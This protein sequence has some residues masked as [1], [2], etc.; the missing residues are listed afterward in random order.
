M[1]GAD[2]A[3]PG[4]F[5]MPTFKKRLFLLRL[6]R[7]GMAFTA[8]LCSSPHSYADDPLEE[9]GPALPAGA[10][11]L[12]PQGLEFKGSVGPWTMFDDDRKIALNNGRRIRIFDAAARKEIRSWVAGRRFSTDLAASPDGRRLASVDAYEHHV[13]IW[14]PFTSKLLKSFNPH[15]G[16]AT[17]SLSFSADG[18]YVA[19]EGS[20]R[21]ANDPDGL[22]ARWDDHGIR[23][24]N[25][26]TGA[27]HPLF[28]GGV[29]AASG[30]AVS[31]DGRWLAYVNGGGANSVSVRPLAGGNEVGFNNVEA[32]H[33][34]PLAFS[35]NGK[36]IA[37]RLKDGGVFVGELATGKEV[38]RFKPEDK[39]APGGEYHQT[40]RFSPD[41]R[42][43]M[44]FHRYF[45][46]TLPVHRIRLWDVENGTSCT[47]AANTDGENGLVFACDGKSVFTLRADRNIQSWDIGTGKES[48]QPGH[49]GAVVGVAITADGKTAATAG[50]DGTVRIWDAVSGAEKHV[51]KLGGA[52]AGVAFLDGGKKLVSADATGEVYVWDAPT[53]KV[54]DRFAA[55][56][57]GVTSLALSPDASTLAT[58]GADSS[59]RLWDTSD[60][61]RAKVLTGHSGW[62]LGVWFVNE[63]KQLLSTSRGGI[64]AP[65]GRSP[66][67]DAHFRLWDLATGK[68]VPAPNLR[69][70]TAVAFTL[71]GKRAV[72]HISA[73][74]NGRIQE[75][76]V[77]TGRKLNDIDSLQP[78]GAGALPRA[79]SP[80]TAWLVA[81]PAYSGPG[82]G[83]TLHVLDTR[84]WT[85]AA[86]LKG[87]FGWVNAAAFSA[88]GRTLV[89]GGEDGKAIVWDLTKLVPRR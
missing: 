49:V 70:T 22:K 84:M 41:N 28:V 74:N 57:G 31:P 55:H 2:P 72:S 26:E 44:T 52:A 33:G 61:T 15:K 51:L 69:A 9:D 85:S 43:V 59:V 67:G 73:N 65:P 14:D 16:Y 11:M 8:L 81:V 60:W 17:G 20:E 25:I 19:T 68:A 75:W 4:D 1:T 36:Y 18:K 47:I 62:V 37:V 21:D 42:T 80:D 86:T 79:F 63:G 10:V 24:V 88:D 6:V 30:P 27:E 76:E 13:H 46:G 32:A 40:V 35:P 83:A 89:T 38:R 78:E 29:R 45:E 39:L 82:G 34:R 7:L 23:I 50:K 12:G 77:A 53:G 56:K 3:V 71:D 64:W 66:D 48:P 58:G 54:V 87:H 5:A